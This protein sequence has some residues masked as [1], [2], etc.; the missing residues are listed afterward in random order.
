MIKPYY[1]DETITIYNASSEDV[2]PQLSG[3][4]SC[5]TD[6]PYG[7]SFMG[8]KWD[9]D[10]PTVELWKGVLESLLPGAHLLSFAGTRTKHRMAV[11]I[12]DGGFEIRDM[13]AW[14]YGSGFPKSLNVGK[15]FDK[16][17][18]NERDFVSKNP[19]N[20]PYNLTFG[21]TSTGWKSPP[22]PDKDKG[23]SEW[24]GYGTALKPALE[25]ITLARKPVEG[26]ILKVNV[27]IRK[28][29]V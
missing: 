18:G 9:Y 16:V 8:K 3:V 15:A 23:T 14:V 20:R 27:A 24:E 17:N 6:P 28:E 2:L 10:V 7:I 29:I 11:R 13:I 21:E 12:E 22:R 26:T 1:Q 5:V 19:A 4:H 25:P